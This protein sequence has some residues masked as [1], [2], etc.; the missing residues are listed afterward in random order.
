[1]RNIGRCHELTQN[2]AGTFSVD[3]DYPYRLLFAPAH[4]P[5]PTKADGGID[6]GAVTTIEILE[7]ENTHGK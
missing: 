4:N 5:V 3:L 2:R 6:W 1:M 7:V